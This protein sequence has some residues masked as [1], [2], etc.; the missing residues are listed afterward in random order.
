MGE[1]YR[2]QNLVDGLSPAPLSSMAEPRPLSFVLGLGDIGM[3]LRAADKLTDMY[4][5]EDTM[6]RGGKVSANLP[7]EGTVAQQLGERLW[8]GPYCLLNFEEAFA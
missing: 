8:K 7:M 4:A 5:T 2:V 3:F 6:E 1:G